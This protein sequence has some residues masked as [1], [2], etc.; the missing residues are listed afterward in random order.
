[1]SVFHLQEARRLSGHPLRYHRVTTKGHAR[2]RNKHRMQQRRAAARAVGNGVNV[3]AMPI[4]NG[5]IVAA[6]AIPIENGVKV[7]AM[8]AAENVD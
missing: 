2:T 4:E 1:M 7:A 6:A 5:V 8:A 3:A